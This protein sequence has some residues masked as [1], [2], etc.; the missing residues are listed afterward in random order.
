MNPPDPDPSPAGLRWQSRDYGELRKYPSDPPIDVL[1][2]GSGYG[3]A[4]AAAELATW[5]HADGTR[6]RICVLERGK[7]Y[8]PG[9]FPSSLQEL[10]PHVRVHRRG[11]EKIL[12]RPDALL[13]VRIGPHVSALLG[14]GLGGTSLI[15][16]GVMAKPRWREGQHLPGHIEQELE[17]L[18]DEVRRKLHATSRFTKENPVLQGQPLAKTTALQR[19]SG[20]G[21]GAFSHADVTVQTQPG[22]PEF[23]P[24][25]LCGDCM[26]G[27]N[28]G[29]KRSLDTTLLAQAR[30]AGVELY[31]GGTVL[32]VE[33]DPRGGWLVHTVYT[34]ASLRS[35]HEPLKIHAAKVILAAGTLGSTE[36]LMHSRAAVSPSGRLGS[37]FSCNGDNL[38]AAHGGPAPVDT[39]TDEWKPL[40]GRKVGPTITGIVELAWDAGEKRRIPAPLMEEFAVPAPLKRL[41]D[42]TVTTAGL[43]NR[44]PKRPGRSAGQRNRKL[45][46]M[47]VDPDAMRNTLLVG[48]V[49]H[50]EAQGH[51]VIPGDPA[52]EGRAGVEWSEVR[53]SPWLEAGYEQ[54]R[55]TLE[56]AGAGAVLPN[57]AWRP[58]PKEMETLVQERGPVLTVHP[59]GGCPMGESHLDGVVNHLGQVFRVTQ[60][61]SEPWPDLVVLDGSILPGSVGA[62]PAL[63]N[64]TVAL[65]ASRGLARQWEWIRA[66]PPRAQAPARAAQPAAPAG[67]PAGVQLAAASAAS[68]RHADPVFQ[69][70]PMRRWLAALLPHWLLRW[71]TGWLLDPGES[72]GGSKRADP[73]PALPPVV[74]PRPVYR[75]PAQCTPPQPQATEVELVE[76]LAGKAGGY[77]VELT[78]C[79]WRSEL[80]QLTGQARREVHLYAPKSWLRIYDD[81]HDARRQLLTLDE[82]ERSERALFSAQLRGSLAIREEVA[83]FHT[84]VRVLR[85]M[86]AWWRNRG[87]RELWD[88]F[89]GVID[90]PFQAGVFLASAARAAERRVFAYDLRVGQVERRWTGAAPAPRIGAGT[91]VRGTKC[92]TYALHGNPWQQL[93]ELQLHGFPLGGDP[94]LK[95]DCRFIVKQGVPLLRIIRQENQVVALAEFA[96][97]ALC[98]LRMLA[99]I[100]LWSF[101]APDRP[102]PRE[103]QLLPGRIAGLP[104]PQVLEL[105]LEDGNSPIRAFVR[106]TRY[107]NPG[108]PPVALVHGYSASGTT[109]THAAIPQPLARHL[110]NAGRDVWVLDLRTSAGMPTALQPWHFEDAAFADLPRAL[111]HIRAATQQRVG[112]V[113][114]CIGA[115]MLSMA[116]LTD[117]ADL[118]RFDHK[119]GDPRPTPRRWRAELAALQDNIDRIVLCQKGPVLVYCDDNVLR[120]YFQR[121]LRRLVFDDSYQFRVPA[122]RTLA[123]NL[124]DRVLSTLPYPPGEFER[125]NPEVP[126][127]RTPWAGFR[128]R[129]DALYARDFKLANLADTTL[130]AI[131]DL[132]GPLNLDTVAQA[133]HFARRN[134]ITDANGVPFDTS[135]GVLQKRWPKRGT[136]S[137]HGSENGLADVKTLD[138]MR[139]QMAF[140][141]IPYAAVEIPGYGHQD[142][143]I[144][145]RAARDV[146][147][148][149]SANV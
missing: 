106:L 105:P 133:I 24:C 61:G 8:A 75:R 144:G 76:R 145:R 3:G 46:S 112:V 60:A 40:V 110:W 104:Q 7:E 139:T 69:L 73:G 101:R 78:L 80:E 89:T 132:F 57:P 30:A 18:F 64:A 120:A 25:S 113:A 124:M 23:P 41:F 43:L 52:L 123:G 35:R 39:T 13:D 66:D 86:H 92:L 34:D 83:G 71:G 109:F 126:W 149:I 129:M 59:L 147:P 143:L 84:P 51:V 125:E 50:D 146:F 97:F 32:Q 117:P 55:R 135:R 44:L 42:E 88:L 16:A 19:V 93:T 141:G 111:A 33:R 1:V 94:V 47:A 72:A 107:A 87:K 122:D 131:E 91:P 121:L 74:H 31:T 138:A 136:V 65:R 127:E 48:L 29:A 96:S 142:C 11:R 14:N 108:Q 4:M 67:A 98:W 140:A 134:T 148:H 77:W 99:S 100:H 54:A 37:G 68:L 70:P 17:P 26:T 115:V 102:A 114:H 45:D 36:I 49:G 9:M 53:K 5:R 79:Y 82:H 20:L 119:P 27:C 10:P 118:A 116:L 103:P 95:L 85:A 12:G 28:V 62:N 56:R 22:D 15:N 2:V 38:V 90:Q 63:T 58:V 130:A 6:L 81:S 21:G 128:H 137:I